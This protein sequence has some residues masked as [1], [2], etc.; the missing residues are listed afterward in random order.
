MGNRVLVVFSDASFGGT[1]R[2]AIIAARCWKRLSYDVAIFPV[3]PVPAGRS[4]E[5]ADFE[6]VKSFADVGDI[7]LV[8]Y[9]HGAFDL[10]Q[11]QVVRG[12]L[13][14]VADEESTPTLLTNNIFGASDRVLDDWP[15][16]RIVGCLGVWAAAQYRANSPLKRV[17]VRIIP[18]AQDSEFWRLPSDEERASA[19]RRF[20]VTSQRWLR[21]GSPHK[22]KWSEDYIALAKQAQTCQSLLTLVCPPHALAER[23][24]GMSNVQIFERPM[25]DE[26]LRDLYWASTT[27]AHSSLRGESFGNVIFEALLCGLPVVYRARPF[28]DNSPWELRN[29]SGFVYA[30]GREDWV[31]SVSRGV[32]QKVDRA[33]LETR[34]SQASVAALL[35]SSIC[36][37]LRSATNVA[38]MRTLG[39]RNSARLL[40]RHNPVTRLAKGF[41]LLVRGSVA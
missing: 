16:P 13:S 23:L 22:E 5:L 8:H 24:R 17:A 10:S 2:S 14:W 20:P 3:L 34:Y 19:L 30:E 37:V 38:L 35:D 29:L 28:R 27:F 12:L 1:S 18:N 39:F 15:G 7:Q 26:E 36:Y 21:V 33:A 31:G 6:V 4:S 41:R 25:M 32:D 11:L 40:V 9:H